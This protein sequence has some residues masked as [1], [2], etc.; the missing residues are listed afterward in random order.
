[1]ATTRIGIREFRE[2][3]S[4]VIEGD[5]AVA[6]TRHGETVGYYIPARRRPTKEDIAR[7]DAAAAKVHAQMAA[8][9]VTEEELVAEFEEA[10][11]RN[12]LR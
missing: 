2:N 1:M 6:I 9:G 4:S 7:L 8:A 5:S 10:R 12:R 11:R 3:L